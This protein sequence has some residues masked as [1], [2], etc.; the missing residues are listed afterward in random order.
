[1]S[2][3]E[4]A[5][6]SDRLITVQARV[7]GL[8]PIRIIAVTPGMSASAGIGADTDMDTADLVAVDLGTVVGVT[9]A[10]AAGITTKT[11]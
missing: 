9:V 7:T 6:R 8:M 2:V 5:C 4:S 1:M 3:S 10:T 11:S